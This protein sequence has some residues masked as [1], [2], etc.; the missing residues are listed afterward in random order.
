MFSVINFRRQA[1]ATLLVVLIML[2]V[3]T[4]FVVSMIRLS[5]TN[6]KV[7]N[8]MQAQRALESS[9]QQAIENKISSITFFND[10]IGNTGQWPAGTNTVTQNVNSYTV[11][12]SRPAC[13]YSQPA[14][15]YSAVS[16]ISPED[17][18]WEVTATSSD[19]ITG[20]NMQVTQGL[21]MRLA[22]GNC[23]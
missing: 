12:I 19:P 9:A 4:L 15:G 14:T 1:G 2:V 11:T 18:N 21:H 10:A 7:V 22:A 23:P 16:Q 6:L 13:T 17:T 8:N 20:A 3:L 5:S